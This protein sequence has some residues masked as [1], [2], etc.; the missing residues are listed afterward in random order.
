MGVIRR[1]VYDVPT[2]ED[3]LINTFVKVFTKV[4]TFSKS[5][6]FAAWM[7]RIAIREALMMHRKTRKMDYVDPAEMPVTSHSPSILEE[8]EK[9]D[10]YACMDDLPDGYRHV[11]NLYAIDG[12]KHREIAELL[13][14]SIHTSKSQLRM[15]RKRFAELLK[16]NYEN[17]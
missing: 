11:L 4:Q 14:I 6:S 10:I 16:K 15:A 13:D 17:E 12:Y 5:G 2:A 8:L 3:I 9:D 1:Y 7:R